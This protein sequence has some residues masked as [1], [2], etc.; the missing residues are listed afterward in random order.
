ME[1]MKQLVMKNFQKYEENMLNNRFFPGEM[2]DAIG[3]SMVVLEQEKEFK[4]PED[5]VKRLNYLH[6]QYYI[7]PRLKSMNIADPEKRLIVYG[8]VRDVIDKEIKV[9]IEEVKYPVFDFMKVFK[10]VEVESEQKKQFD[11]DGVIGIIYPDYG[12]DERYKMRR[13]IYGF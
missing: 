8:G 1:L 10:E 13:R 3:Q 7:Q 12:Y 2:G 9:L 6:K 11:G 4:I 5:A